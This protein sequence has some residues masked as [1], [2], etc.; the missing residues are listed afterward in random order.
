MEEDVMRELNNEMM[1]AAIFPVRVD[2][3]T[4]LKNK[5]NR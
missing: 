5:F 1:V 2:F 3:E 4:L